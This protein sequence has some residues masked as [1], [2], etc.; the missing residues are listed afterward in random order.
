MNP[1]D[2]LG[3]AA[4]GFALLMF[5]QG[6]KLGDAWDRIAYL[7][8]TRELREERFLQANLFLPLRSSTGL[9]GEAG[10]GG[11]EPHADAVARSLTGSEFPSLLPSDSGDVGTLPPAD[12]SLSGAR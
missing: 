9:L 6:F 10:Q 11:V 4:L 5:A 12:R 3:Y 1:V 8:D 7:Q 2:A